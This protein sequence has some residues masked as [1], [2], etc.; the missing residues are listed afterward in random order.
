MGKNFRKKN[1]KTRP[2]SIFRRFFGG[3][4]R[5]FGRFLGRKGKSRIY[6]G[7]VDHF[8]CDFAS[9]AI[10]NVSKNVLVAS[11]DML[12]AIDGDKVLVTITDIKKKEPRGVIVK[13]LDRKHKFFFGVLKSDNKGILYLDIRERNIYCKVN[14]EKNSVNED[15]KVD[16]RV[17][18]LIV[19]Y[20]DKNN[21]TFTC[22]VT[23][24]FGPVGDHESEIKA[25]VNTYGLPERFEPKV[26]DEAE[27]MTIN[28]NEE[29]QQ[30][31][32]FRDVFTVT[33]DPTTAKD[34]DDAISFREIDN[35]RY[36]IGVHIADVSHFVKPKTDLDR[37]AYK[38]NTSVYLIDRVI[39]MLPERLCNDLCSL[40]ERED[41][42]T[43]SIVF[44]MS[45][46]GEVLN[47]WIGE[48]II[49]SNHRMTYEQAQEAIMNSS[50][51]LHDQLSVLF[52]I[53][54]KLRQKRF[55]NG[56][57]NFNFDDVEFGVDQDNLLQVTRTECRESHNM[58]EE[59]MLL[60]NEHVATYVYN[61]I[62]GKK[63]KHPVFIYRTHEAPQPEKINDFCNLMRNFKI[64][65]DKDPQKFPQQLNKFLEK[66][67]GQENEGVFSTLAVR[68]MARA[69]YSTKP[70][71]H[72][73]L[74]FKHYTHFT[75][76][77]R[78]YVDITV[79]RLLKRYL[80][81]DFE[82]DVFKYER[83]CSYA[84]EREEVATDVE[85]ETI[86]FKQVD[87]LKDHIGEKHE[88]IV[89]GITDIGMFIEVKSIRC[90]GFL[91]FSEYKYDYLTADKVHGKVVGSYTGN[92]YCIGDS[93]NVK[94]KNCNV[95]RRL[96][97]FT[98]VVD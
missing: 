6:V 28:V 37:E 19:R 80:K 89:T 56:A 31:R 24:V 78:R 42:L 88:G 98:F 59:F 38:R 52:G 15:L 83:L 1:N 30:R 79:H 3:I 50:H 46:Q 12:T 27:K 70:Q 75:S 11:S 97:D 73:G 10:N 87:F 16:T 86:K 49:N 40:V 68:T 23:E 67:R 41:R 84:N 51:E 26:I 7:F 72:F 92:T 34:F 36:E 63:R 29:L 17:K 14:I 47:E 93:I 62:T 61:I 44:E 81:G 55:E 4:G 54:S 2:T 35:N 25:I 39:P 53:S 13:V 64:N 48:T 85:R 33:I 22:R 60:A 32:D 95:E 74:A 91:R 18:A 66:I 5:F 8:N 82:F 96:V 94:I 57:I 65:I 43:M 76:P 58:I 9:V 90:D 21:R 77:I 45:S 69:L 20:P 71:G